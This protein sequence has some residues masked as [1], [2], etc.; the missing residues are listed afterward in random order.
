[1]ASQIANIDLNITAGALEIGQSVSIF[2]MGILT[3]QCFLYFR[4]FRED[5]WWL[6][7]VVRHSR[8]SHNPLLLIS[9]HRSYLFGI[10]QILISFCKLYSNMM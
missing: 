9:L 2:L 10:I 3:M 5:N 1:M 8:A 7:A 4:N 6:K